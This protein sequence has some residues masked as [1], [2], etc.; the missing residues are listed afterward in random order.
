MYLINFIGIKRAIV[1]VVFCFIAF[2]SFSQPL[3][4]K[5]ID[6]VNPSSIALAPLY[7]LASDELW[8]DPRHDRR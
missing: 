6:Q 4:K 5:Q 7:F 2:A 1:T 8:E 3:V